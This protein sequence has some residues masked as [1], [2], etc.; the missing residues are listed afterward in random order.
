M[1]ELS[2]HIVSLSLAICV[3]V[4]TLQVARADSI[5]VDLSGLVNSDL[6]GYSGGG[7]YPQHGGP[8][9]VDRKPTR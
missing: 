7:N 6:T 9:T 1:K 4:G 3:W 5:S 2:Q 8:I